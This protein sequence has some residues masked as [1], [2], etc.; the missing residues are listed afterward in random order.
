MAAWRALKKRLRSS[1]PRIRRYLHLKV[2]QMGVSQ[3]YGYR[4]GDLNNK[5]Y[6]ILGVYTG[7]PLFRETTR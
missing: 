3:N 1:R 2:E 6:K 7:V 4:F 5:D